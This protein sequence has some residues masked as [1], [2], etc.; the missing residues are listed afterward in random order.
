MADSLE[1]RKKKPIQGALAPYADILNA[2]PEEDGYASTVAKGVLRGG[3]GL[4]KGLAGSGLRW[5]GEA[6][7]G[8]SEYIAPDSNTTGL[9]LADRLASTGKTISDV[10]DME[11]QE[12]WMAPDQQTFGGTF[13]ENPSFKRAIGI[14][15][16]AVPSLAAAVTTGGLTGSSLA[17]ASLLGF[18]GGASQYEEAREAGKGVGEASIY[19]GISTVG[20]TLLEKLPIDHMLKFGGGFAKGAVKGA[21]EEGAQEGTQQL[22]QNL[23]AKVGYEPTRH[24][25]EGI[26]ESVIGGAG[27]GGA[28]GGVTGAF[29][30]AVA[31]A[32]DSG[33]SDEEIHQAV[34]SVSE[35]LADFASRDPQSFA[36]ILTSQSAHEVNPV[37][38][39]LQQMEQQ[40]AGLEDLAKTDLSAAAE[41]DL[42]NK[43]SDTLRNNEESTQAKHDFELEQ[44]KQ[45]ALQGDAGA[46]A[47]LQEL[48]KIDLAAATASEG[49][50]QTR[51]VTPQEAAQQTLAQVDEEWLALRGETPSIPPMQPSAPVEAD[52]MTQLAK[53]VENLQNTAK[54]SPAPR[55]RENLQKAE[56]QLA[57]L[58]GQTQQASTQAAP[59]ALEPF[60][61]QQSPLRNPAR[62]LP[63]PAVRV[64]PNG[65]AITS[66]QYGDMVNQGVAD[67]GTLGMLEGELPAEVVG[68]LQQVQTRIAKLETT[69]AKSRSRKLQQNLAK[70]KQREAKILE[71][72]QRH[73][74]EVVKRQEEQEAPAPQAPVDLNDTQ[75][76]FIASKVQELGS[77]E[78]VQ[79][80]Y[81]SD[82]A[83]DLFARQTAQELFGITERLAEQDAEAH[84][85]EIETDPARRQEILNSIAEGEMLVKSGKDTAGQ[86][87]TQAKID[88]IQRSVDGAK[89]K[90]GGVLER[91][92]SAD[93][94]TDPFAEPSAEEIERTAAEADALDIEQSARA[95][96][97]LVIDGHE[98]NATI[99]ANSGAQQWYIAAKYN[100]AQV[101]Q[102]LRKHS[103]GEKLADKQQQILEA[104]QENNRRLENSVTGNAYEEDAY[105][106]EWGA[107][108]R[109]LRD[110]FGA[111]KEVDEAA[112]FAMM[113]RSGSDAE[114]LRG[115]IAITEAQN[116]QSRAESIGTDQEGQADR[117]RSE[118]ETAGIPAQKVGEDGKLFA[119]PPAFGKKSKPEGANV[120]T[121]AMEDEMA[122]A[123]DDAKQTG[124]FDAPETTPAYGSTNK[125]VS[126]ERAA[127]LRKKLQAKLDNLNSGIDP[128]TLMLGSELA[129]YHIEA[130]AR[131]FAQFAKVMTEEM[132]AKATPYLKMW[133]MGAKNWPGMDKTGMDSETVVDAAE[134]DSAG[135]GESLAEKR[136]DITDSEIESATEGQARQALAEIRDDFYRGLQPVQK[137]VIRKMDNTGALDLDEARDVLRAHRA[138]WVKRNTDDAESDSKDTEDMQRRY[139]D[140]S[141][142]ELE[143]T[144]AKITADITSL[145]N[146]GRNEVRDG[147]R[148]T[149]AATSNEAARGLGEE[150]LRLERYLRERKEQETAETQGGKVKTTGK[151]EDLPI[152]VSPDDLSYQLAYNAHQGT[153]HVPDQRAK[154]EQQMYV[155]AMRNLYEEMAPLAKT[156]EQKTILA[157]EME[158]YK[159]RYLNKYKAALSARS[160]VMSAMITGPARFPTRSN[161][162]KSDTADKRISEFL[163]WE[164]K[165]RKAIRKAIK[166]ED[167]PI[168]TTDKNAGELLQKK[169]D[170]A[171]EAQEKMKAANKIIRSGKNVDARLVEL[172]FSEKVAAEIQKPDFG[173]RVGFARYQLTN[174][175]AEIKR[176]KARLADVAKIQE[177]AQSDQKEY[178][179][180]GGTVELDYDDG[181]LRL[182]FDEK[183]SEEVRTQL[184][185]NG[186]RWSPKNGAWQR[187]LTDNAKAAATRL[188][189]VDFTATE[190]DQGVALYQ[191][192]TDSEAFIAAPDGTQSFGEIGT[193]TAKTIRRQAG[194][195]RL[196]VGKDT[197]GNRY[198]L[199][200]VQAQRQEYLAKAGYPDLVAFIHSVTSAYNEIRQGEQGRLFLVKRNGQLKTAVVQLK[201]HPTGDFY[202]VESAWTT[203]ERYVN[204]KQLLWERSEPAQP[205]PD[206]GSYSRSAYPAEPGEGQPSAQG[207]SSLSL[208][209]IT[210]SGQPSNTGLPVADLQTGLND[211]LQQLPGALGKVNLVQNETE[212]PQDLQDAIAREKMNGAFDGVYWHGKVHLVADNLESLESAQ[213]A[214]LHETRHLGLEHIL[215]G[216]K[217]P[218]LAQT[219]AV[220]NKGVAAYLK[221]HKM[222]NTPQNRLMAAEEVLVDLAKQGST[223][224]FLDSVVTKVREWVRKVFPNLN[225]SK[226][227]LRNLIA[228][229]DDFLTSGVDGTTFVKGALAPAYNREEDLTVPVT[230]IE[231]FDVEGSDLWR[232]ANEFYREKLQGKTVVNPHIGE[233]QFTARGRT[234]A[235]SVGR[236]DQRRMSIVRSLDKLA[237]KAVFLDETEDRKERDGLRRFLRLVAPAEISGEAYAVT[238]TVREES[239]GNKKFYTVAGYEMEPSAIN[240]GFDDDA[241]RPQG[242]LD[243]KITVSQLKSAVK[244][245]P[246]FSRRN[247]VA[248]SL[249]D[250]P[251]Q[252]TITSA[253][254]GAF[255]AL[256]AT[257]IKQSADKARTKL[258]D[259]MHPIEQLGEKA[260][261]LHRLLGNTHV[262]LSTFLQH[263]KL[264]WDQ[265]TLSVK[266]KDQGFLPWLKTLG[267]DGRNVFYWVAAKR[268]E[269]LEKEGRENWLTADKRNALYDEIFTGLTP[270]QRSAKEKEF[271]EHNKKFQAFNDNII[272]IAKEAG[273]VSQEQVD[274]WMRDFYLPFYRIMEDEQTQDEFI[275]S[276]QKSKKHISAQ[277]KRL[278]G[279]EEKIGD[280]VENVLRNWAHMIQESQR[281]IARKSAGPVAISL[282]LAKKVPGNG[283]FKSP[284]ARRENSIISYQENGKPVYLEVSDID[285]FE[286]LAETNAKAFDSMLLKVLGS[287]KRV[288]TMGATIGPAFRVANLLRDTLHTAVVS[289]SFA[290]FVDTTKGLVQVWKESP[291]YIALMASGGGFGQGWVDSG[292]PKAMARSIEKI[293][294]REGEGSRG[295]ILD[296]P[297]KMW[298]FWERTGHASEMAARVQLYTNLKMKGESNLT[299]AYEARDLLDFYRTGSSNAVRMLSMVTPFLNA[300]IQ[301]MD[302]MYRGAKS[303]PKAFLTKGALISAAS[304]MLWALFHDDDR[305]KDMEDWEKWQYHHFWI[306]DQHFRIPKAFEVGALF[307]TLPESAAAAMSGDEEGEFFLRFLGHTLT[308][309]FSVGAPAAFA[310][311]MEV[312]ANK[313]AFTG[314]PLEGMSLER[315]PAGE[316]SKPWTPELLKDL[317]KGLNLS[318]IKMEH[319]IQ[320]HFAVLGTSIL[321]AAD[322]A[323]RWGKGSP[324]QPAPNLNN[325]PGLGRFVRS[326]AGRSKYATRYYDLAREINEL[327][328]T[329]SHYK[330][331]G[332]FSKARELSRAKP[333][334]YKRFVNL[335][336]QRLSSLAKQGRLIYFSTSLSAGSKRKKLDALNE[337][338]KVIYQQAYE[339]IKR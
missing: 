255:N 219:A 188:F 68:E 153:S 107:M 278:E 283:M 244:G 311:A 172:G 185:S 308:E 195:I 101:I 83:V 23:I 133:Y 38:K 221:Q 323:Y 131:Q 216:N 4:V 305:Y 115:L 339:R 85:A 198:G 210:Q 249:F 232:T 326:D 90:L 189:N 225:L 318:P 142:Q 288:L 48:A 322:A 330:Q 138:Y 154:Q 228:G 160:R 75:R 152:T 314:R 257:D 337:R 17:G 111:A 264:S 16:E 34:T 96:E 306:G 167:G 13:I 41:L 3:T 186:F 235:L 94:Q 121:L 105:D 201:P 129:V 316:R 26:V 269:V 10:A 214:L 59:N 51:P 32:K 21:L 88:A 64:T 239:I 240:R 296:T 7:G 304:L 147:K 313:S 226:A 261:M 60:E 54:V 237:E 163:E 294:K 194:A 174:N 281:N 8:E 212:L 192:K 207:Q 162:K 274:S 332:D 6:M 179:F 25:A 182:L 45:V 139:G 312:Y 136:A 92:Y 324:A 206:A 146:A 122:E 99:S 187:Q 302:R 44:V 24:L 208:G 37:G 247:T 20:N 282:G 246:A 120:S 119:T 27:S 205:S 315:L 321:T 234:K 197:P 112:A 87:M 43:R 176:L 325:L 11:L 125:L 245:D 265:E 40:A 109:K 211:S 227:E 149:K 2:P 80:Q 231:P 164:K 106:P 260:Y 93:E 259:R 215:G 62:L 295:R 286:A 199:V 91:D 118:E 243:S 209:S 114:I 168:R 33:A 289:K 293:V 42:L 317:G 253:I 123:A 292:D 132:G 113:K 329:V 73:Q 175:N 218:V 335:T 279:G 252:H 307:S 336:S 258:V 52:L 143:A 241:V 338:R 276:P 334:Q 148:S 327:S 46:I 331:L 229:A 266:E 204:G 242:S 297:R 262:T 81:G 171:I 22:W 151:I 166:P 298:E 161:Q 31:K 217:K 202:T 100:I 157:A 35:Q 127:E 79:Q 74:Q 301:G 137:D 277:I 159:T 103:R 117:L 104:W 180:D 14:I 263:G 158:Q 203:N 299:A 67:K 124:M 181:R 56:A 71:E 53:R 70:A 69:P 319:M 291:D 65:T 57:A 193:A 238:L 333:M 66:Q 36:S 130:G 9:S 30:K 134:V 144:L 287:A 89:E 145:Q 183:P 110:A 165:A 108:E 169:L 29:N 95:S 98:T 328:A 270:E 220:F 155:N 102:T 97:K 190:T 141:V 248:D 271:T 78:A 1:S 72:V 268:A 28:I 5:A 63:A 47:K 272:T 309:T 135:Q 82:A 200:H 320:G 177:A 273:L 230:A 290:P 76:Q 191:R 84:P 128:E 233:I 12:G 170:S 150:K 275:S 236:H 184:K 178:S 49:I 224:K 126:A 86:P 310:P 156:E 223:H 213:K 254:N 18:S 19:G 285:L 58:R 300:R 15:S 196:Q 284:G 39:M 267:S 303:D 140:K 55:V 222:K 250:T 50:N 251:E 256:K 77:V 280:P 61:P 173:G 116:G